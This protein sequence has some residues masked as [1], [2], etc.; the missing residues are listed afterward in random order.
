MIPR[1][2]FLYWVGNDYKLISILRT[3][4]YL[5]S[6]NGKGYNIILINHDNL[7]MYIKDIPKYF[8]EL[9]PAHQADFVRVHVICDHGGIWLD[10][11]TLVLNS[12]DPLFNLLE[13]NDGFLIKEN[14]K[15]L[16][17]G[18]FGSIPN[19]EFLQ[20]WK[21]QIRKKLDQ[22]NGK[23]S[24]SDIGSKL[25]KTMYKS[26]P[27][28]F[29]KYKIYNGLD[30]LYPINWDKAKTEFIDKPYDNYKNI[31]RNFQPIVVLVNTVYKALEDNTIQEILNS[32]KPINYF[33]NKSFQNF[34]FQNYNIIQTTK[35]NF[36]TLNKKNTIYYYLDNSNII[37]KIYHI[38]FIPDNIKKYIIHNYL[39]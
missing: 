19:T 38:P 2:L 17:N 26:S 1:N 31:I 24:W 36:N 29:Q 20:K 4:I 13:K 9:C 39:K 32:D 21:Q 14:N 16:W 34:P 25:L 10:S 15:I 5:H 6:T 8:F 3:L 27:H 18:V 35:D 7:N 28:L 22:K 37:M 23:I 33:I 11:D 12:L 30:N